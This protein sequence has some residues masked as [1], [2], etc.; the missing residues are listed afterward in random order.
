MQHALFSAQVQPSC[1]NDLMM[2]EVDD[3]ESDEV[4]GIAT[5]WTRET[6]P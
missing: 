1:S 3:V 6:L 2:F 4:T 5:T